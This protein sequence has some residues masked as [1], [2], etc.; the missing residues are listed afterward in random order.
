M[1]R[2]VLLLL[3]VH[4]GHG[5]VEQQHLRLHG[6]GAPRSTRFAGRRATGPRGLAKRL[7]FQEVDDVLDL[8]AV[9][10]FFAF[11][12][13]NAQGLHEDVA[14]DLEVA[15]GRDV[16]DHAHAFEQRQVLEGAA[17]AHLGDLARVHAKGLARKVMAPSWGCTRH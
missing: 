9:G 11:C 5:F 15:A 17:N 4:A 14:L 10:H 3:H 6:Q 7:D 16:V 13:T 12:R 1:K 8:L 2:H